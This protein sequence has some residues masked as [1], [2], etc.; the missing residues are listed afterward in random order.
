ML[1]EI[2]RTENSSVVVLDN[3]EMLFARELE[4]HPLRLLQ[5]LSRN[6][7]IIAP[8]PG[9][10]DD[11]CL[12]YGEP[13]HPEACRYVSPQAFIVSADTSTASEVH[14]HSLFLQ[15]PV[16]HP[17]SYRRRMRT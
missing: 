14:K 11:G 1:D 9:T 4:Q 7:T 8:W 3:I 10:I 12:T 13:G 2:V 6:L 5:G 17:R 16:L 15:I